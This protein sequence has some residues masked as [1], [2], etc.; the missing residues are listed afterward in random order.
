[1]VTIFS[2]LAEGTARLK[3]NKIDTPRLDAEVILSCILG[4]PRL[5]VMTEGGR[6][7]TDSAYNKFISS[8][9][10]RADGMPVAY[11]VGHKE[12]MG[13]D[14][15]VRQGVLIPRGDTEIVAERVICE[16]RNYEGNVYIADVGCGSGAIGISAA[17]NALNADVTLIDISDAALEVALENIALNNVK[18]RVRAVKGDLLLPVQNKSFDIVA[19][20]PP[21]IE[22]EVIKT[23][24][25]DVR[26]YEPLLAL[27]GGSDG[28]DFYNRLTPQAALSLNTPGM[29]IYEIGYNQAKAVGEILI[30]NGFKD[31]MVYKDLSGL[32]R[33]ITGKKY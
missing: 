31:V 16:C 30:R 22:T 4:L 5:T 10:D 7:L 8:I 3:S 14:F 29:L 1:M 2:A 19:S 15:N 11:I 28:L 6:G 24:Q 25:R 12:F 13:L 23:L 33:C 17:K 26:E 18:D 32:D 20:N 9:K 21:Y 27:D